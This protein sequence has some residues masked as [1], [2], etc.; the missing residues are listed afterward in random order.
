MSLSFDAIEVKRDQFATLRSK[1][2]IVG[3]YKQNAWTIP[4]IVSAYD[5]YDKFIWYSFQRAPLL[6]YL[7]RK[8]W[9]LLG[10]AGSG[11]REQSAT[12]FQ[13]TT[14]PRVLMGSFQNF[15]GTFRGTGRRVCTC[16][17]SILSIFMG[18]PPTKIQ[19]CS[20]EVPHLPQFS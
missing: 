8:W 15:N 18:A 14:S 5:K 19:S 11:K 9:L 7:W 13:I 16:E 3:Y 17:I 6:I 12:F 2:C 20:L 4:V 1:S 10:L